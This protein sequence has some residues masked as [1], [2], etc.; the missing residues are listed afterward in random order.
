MGSHTIR[1][2]PGAFFRKASAREAG[3]LLAL[4]WFV[5]FAIHL[6][7]WSGMRPLGAYLLPMFWATFVAAYFHGG[8][9]GVVVGL[10][11]PGINLVVTGL[12]AWRFLGVLSFEL[13][14]YAL[15]ATWAIRR[16]PRFMLIAPLGYLVAKVAS[17][18]LQ[19][20]TPIFGEI[21][22]PL[23]FFA[24][25]IVGGLAGLIVLGAINAALVWYYPKPARAAA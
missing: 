15:A 2:A 23:Q 7:P 22:S 18:G 3:V 1:A 25:S 8:K 17:T 5:P 12:P 16:V 20:V 6:V 11:A 13:V 19:M 9:M 4:A 10:F 21:G 24:H 14:I